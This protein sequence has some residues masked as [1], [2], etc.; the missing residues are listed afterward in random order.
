MIEAK[1]LKAYTKKRN[2]M[3]LLPLSQAR[4]FLRRLFHSISRWE[5]DIAA[6]VRLHC[7]HLRNNRILNTEENS[8]TVQC[9]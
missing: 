4:G 3:S 1:S 7:H 5:E 8:F 9:G 2:P 6:Q